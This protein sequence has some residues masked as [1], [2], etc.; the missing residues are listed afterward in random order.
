MGPSTT[1]DGHSQNPAE[2]LEKAMASRIRF[3]E[4]YLQRVEPG[5][6]PEADREAMRIY[7]KPLTGNTILLQGLAKSDSVE[8][9]KAKIEDQLGILSN[10]QNLAIPFQ[11]KVLEHGRSLQDYNIQNDST[12]ELKLIELKGDRE[13]VLAAVGQKGRA[14]EYA[15]EELRGDGEVVLA[16]VVQN[17]SALEYAAAKMR[18]NREVVLAAVGQDGRALEY[19]A[20]EMRGDREVVL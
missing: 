14:L 20:E 18:G 7:V 4:E 1:E 10:Q 15:A 3:L 17:G 2:D 9:V 16:A 11:G 6:E 8:S 12:L 19:A 13:V 5:P